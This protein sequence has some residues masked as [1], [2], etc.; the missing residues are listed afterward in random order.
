MVTAVCGCLMLITVSV[1]IVAI[2]VT[3][4]RVVTMVIVVDVFLLPILVE[5]CVQL[6]GAEIDCRWLGFMLHGVSQMRGTLD[7]YRRIE[8]FRSIHGPGLRVSK[9]KGFFWAIPKKGLWHLEIYI[10][11][12]MRG[13]YHMF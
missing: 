3:V 11:P 6:T 4:G 8:V 10:G 13:N 5:E 7:V 12:P 1:A 2:V 9:I